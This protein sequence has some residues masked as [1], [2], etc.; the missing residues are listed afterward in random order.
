MKFLEFKQQFKDFNVIAHQDIKNV[1]GNVNAVQLSVW[2]RKGYLQSAKRG[3]YIL[4]D[5]QV[6]KLLMA[7]ELNNSYISLEFALSFHQI[8]PEIT[9]SLTSVSSD[10]Q[11]KV[12]NDIGVFYYHKITPK[13][14]TGFTL[15]ESSIKKN[16]FIKIAKP[17][18]AIFDLIYLR[19]DLKSEEDFKSLRLN[20][21]KIEISKIK[22]YIN[23]VEAGSIKSR[24]NNFLEYCDAR[25]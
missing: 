21:E 4:S 13:L 14:F 24:L 6:D 18:K 8:I 2:K 12:E 1:F 19:T 9:Q 5:N 7:N 17:E 16:R 25:I 3:M 10:R 20:L 11:E 23:L 15:I 22:K